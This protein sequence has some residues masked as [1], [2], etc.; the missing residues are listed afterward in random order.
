M[1]HAR[2]NGM[3]AL[4]ALTLLLACSSTTTTAP[5]NLSNPA[6]MAMA[7]PGLHDLYVADPG[8]G[9][10]QVLRFGTNP[11]VTNPTV[12]NYAWLTAPSFYFPLRIPV[13][14][15]L[16][17]TYPTGLAATA[18]GRYVVVLDALGEALYVIDANPPQGAD[19][20]LV[21]EAD[22][23]TPVSLH[24]GP[25]GAAPVSL[26]AAPVATLCS[27]TADQ[28]SCTYDF[29]ITLSGQG[30]IAIAEL[31]ESIPASSGLTAATLDLRNV[32][33]VGGAPMQLAVSPNNQFLFATD[34]ALPTLAGPAQFVRVEI[35][36]GAVS[37]IQLPP[38]ITSGST[39]QSVP[40]EQRA[41]GGAIEVS[42]DGRVV[43]VARPS[44]QDLVFFDGADTETPTLVDASQS[45]GTADDPNRVSRP[46]P[47]C[48]R[49]CS[50]LTTTPD[51]NCTSLDQA[52]PSDLA[53]CMNPNG[54]LGDSS[55]YTSY[56]GLYLGSS[57][58]RLLAF[59]HDDQNATS[60]L[61]LFAYCSAGNLATVAN[62]YV[63]VATD[64]DPLTDGTLTFVSWD[65]APD[66]L[67]GTLR[68]RIVRSDTCA[69]LRTFWRP[70]LWVVPRSPSVR[71]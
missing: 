4:L 56:H 53:M 67:T 18:D 52:H 8:E 21:M 3:G 35:G 61:P 57:P 66:S 6:G 29:Y 17:A 55:V 49:Q 44:L 62:D 58:E 16:V 34:A 54:S 19:P 31:T 63:L 2:R 14:P 70:R 68:P 28:P 24:L 11:V 7:G 12:A 26:K 13:G 39:L 51:A 25:P 5:S 71:I 69:P 36:T 42:G 64:R 30:A 45:V 38:V 10:V 15:Y 20:L 1:D 43:I 47:N 41:L 9:A 48:R 59:H 65:R 27:P 50:N 32:L 22:G 33:A 46:V 23:V 40:S 60:D 37:H